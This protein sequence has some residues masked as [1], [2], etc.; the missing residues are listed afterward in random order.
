MYL[1]ITMYI[2]NGVI[3]KYLELLLVKL[4]EKLLRSAII[5]F[6]EDHC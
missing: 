5:T 2:D 1:T 6:E 4:G 3:M